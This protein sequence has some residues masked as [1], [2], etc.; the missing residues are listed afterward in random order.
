[1]CLREACDEYRMHPA[2]GDSIEAQMRIGVLLH[3]FADTCAHQG[4]SGILEKG[5]EIRL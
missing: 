4:F 2:G 1:M 3:I 5:N